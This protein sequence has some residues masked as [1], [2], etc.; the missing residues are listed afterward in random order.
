MRLVTKEITFDAAHLLTGHPGKCRNLHGHTY[1]LA[2]T[3]EE[4]DPGSDMVID[5]KELKALVE[6]EVADRFD[7]AFMYDARSAVEKS[8]AEVLERNGLRTVPLEFRTTAENLAR[9]VFGLLSARAKI[10]SVKLWETPTSCAEY[11]A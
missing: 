10:H 8:V 9:H 3:V 11:R 1:R 4:A 6:E 7:H 5:F 2:V